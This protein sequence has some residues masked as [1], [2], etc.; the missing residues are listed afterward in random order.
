MPMPMPVVDVD[1]TGV[2]DDDDDDDKPPELMILRL[3]QLAYSR[4]RLLQQLTRFLLFT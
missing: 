4:P 2:D 1:V 3:L